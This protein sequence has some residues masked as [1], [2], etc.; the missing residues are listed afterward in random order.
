MDTGTEEEPNFAGIVL[1]DGEAPIFG[2]G[3]RVRVLDRRP[4]GHYRVPTYLRGKTASVES[5][6]EPP[7]L[8]NEEEGFGRNAGR[9]RHYYRLS[10]PMVEVWP[11]YAASPHDTL[12][13]E[14]FETWLEGI[15]K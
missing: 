6:I 2:P 9:K 1:A 3:D 10:L 13:I 8:N 4:V 7:G 11:A 15:R 14:V 5:V 12:K